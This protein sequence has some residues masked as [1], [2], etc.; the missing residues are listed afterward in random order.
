MSSYF[1]DQYGFTLHGLIIII[2]LPII[3]I[4]ITLLVI[5]D[6]DYKTRQQ[7]LLDGSSCVFL[8]DWIIAPQEGVWIKSF[9]YEFAVKEYNER[10]KV[11]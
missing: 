1:K 2:I 5:A 8:L 11:T 9:D 7:N 3:V 6:H 4:M 10:C